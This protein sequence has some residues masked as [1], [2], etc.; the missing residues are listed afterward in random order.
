MNSR[1][2][3]ADEVIEMKRRDFLRALGAV[4]VAMPSS[5]LAA[6]GDKIPRIAVVSLHAPALAADVEGIREGLSK[7]GYVEGDRNRVSRR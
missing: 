2:A 4:A 7:L 3:R 5:V 1:D 6:G